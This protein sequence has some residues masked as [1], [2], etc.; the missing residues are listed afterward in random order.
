MYPVV[1]GIPDFRISLPP[2]FNTATDVETAR[3]LVE[4]EP[5]LDFEALLHLYYRL[6]PEATDEI[7]ELHMAHLAGE[8]H[9]AKAALDLLESQRPFAA[10]DLVLEV[11]CGFGH[12]LATAG[13]RVEHVVGADLSLAFLI[14][15]RKRL[16]GRGLLVAA[17]AEHLPFRDGTYAAV[18][19]ADVLEHLADQRRCL[20][21]MGRVLAPGASLFLSTPNRY[22]L[23]PEPHVG[24]WGV[25]FLPR[26]WAS[27]YVHRRRGRPY[28]IQLLSSYAL[29]Q[30]LRGAF[31]GSAR[32]VLPGLSAH[33]L[34]YFSP[35]KR[36]LARAYLLL[37]RL[38]LVRSFFY[39]FGPFF[40]V[41]A[42]KR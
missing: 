17:V 21:E 1:C 3:V 5:L 23:T 42:V 33:Q 8:E 35:L 6:R 40:H 34:E 31:P 30:V 13:E 14:V 15:A 7:H 16:G 4:E 26:L 36:R 19:A 32:L 38:P 18:I 10:G 37:R 12:H 20:E 22:S 24:L 25:G 2:H 39:L 29:R 9:Q 27:R 41:V 28:R 11:G